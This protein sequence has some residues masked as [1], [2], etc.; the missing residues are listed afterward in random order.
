[1][2]G[3]HLKGGAGLEGKQNNYQPLMHIT[4]YTIVCVIHIN[5]YVSF[6]MCIE[7]N[8]VDGVGGSVLRHPKKQKQVARV[9]GR[10]H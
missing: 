7:S 8:G 1:M 3:A 4:Y 6:I 9:P 10:M 2:L 5:L